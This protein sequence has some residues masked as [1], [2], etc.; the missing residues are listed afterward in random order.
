MRTS[1]GPVLSLAVM[2]PKD[3]WQEAGTARI[4]EQPGA[5]RNRQ[6]GALS[7]AIL[8]IG[9]EVQVAVQQRGGLAD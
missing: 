1:R 7:T 8:S 3:S 5:G 2:G 4:V 6:C 9:C